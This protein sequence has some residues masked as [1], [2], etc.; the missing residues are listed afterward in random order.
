MS[1]TW[2]DDAEAIGPFG[3]ESSED[4]F[5]GDAE[6]IDFE[7]YDDDA[8]ATVVRDRRRRNEDV[9]A[10]STAYA[11]R[12]ARGRSGVPYSPRAVARRRALARRALARRALAR[13]AAL[14]RARR[15]M[16]PTRPRYPATATGEEPETRAAVRELGLETEVQAAEVG[17]TRAAVQELG[18]ESEEQAEAVASALAAQRRRIGG[19]DAAVGASAVASSLASQLQTSFPDLARNPFVRAGLPMAPLLFL[20]PAKRESGFQGFVSDPRVWAGALVAGVTIAGE[21]NSRIQSAERVRITQFTTFL[22]Q[23]ERVTF[24]AE[25]LDGGGAVLRSKRIKWTEDPNNPG[26]VTVGADDGVVIAGTAKG[27]TNVTATVDGTSVSASVPLT[28]P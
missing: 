18:V 5:D 8:E 20:K 16:A 24:A 23:G 22:A 25:A 21:I 11:R 12:G 17:L 27:Q 1:N 13:R 3:Y 9:P 10:R 2:L 28:V 6:D 26:V 4:Y 7:S 19:N 15:G 14:A